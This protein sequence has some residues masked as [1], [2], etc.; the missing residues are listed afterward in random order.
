MIDQTLIWNTDEALHV[1]SLTARLRELAGVGCID[2][3]LVVGDL[4][5]S[6]KAAMA[7]HQWALAGESLSFETNL[8][9]HR[10]RLRLEPLC[11]PTWYEDLRTDDLAISDGLAALLG[12]DRGITRLNLRSFDHPEEREETTRVINETLTANGSYEHDHR[13]ICDNS[14]AR[15][16]RESVRTIYDARGVAIGRLGTLV[17]ISDFK[18]R[19]NELTELAHYDPLTHLPNRSLLETRLAAS[20]SRAGRHSLH[21]AIL[22]VDIDDFK[23]INDTYG[24]D[25][26]DRVLSRVGEHLGRYVRASDTVSRLGGDEFVVLLEDLMSDDAAVDAA[27][28]IL[29]SFDDPFSIDG[30]RVLVSA[31]I[32]I[33]T[34]PR[35]ATNATDLIGRADREMY[36]V[37]RNG[38][39]GVKLALPI[40]EESE[41][42]QAEN[43]TC[44]TLSSLGQ[45][46]FGTRASA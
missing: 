35:C 44:T 41:S 6:S 40:G 45:Q 39:R 28:K 19:E 31:S 10:Y 11:C 12:V 15:N 3:P 7:A 26:G 13:I 24:H 9:G 36:E 30:H 5:G 21:C 20:L 43:T 37:K 33:A 32:G 1:T 46:V 8:L 25:V 38:G 23:G 22:F 34:Y 16:V 42:V 17:D 18:E 4:W 27:R 2:R 29:R 14:R